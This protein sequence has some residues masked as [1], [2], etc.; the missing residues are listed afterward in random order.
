[1]IS[2]LNL[3]LV[4]VILSVINYSC[5][6]RAESNSYYML[7]LDIGEYNSNISEYISLDY[8]QTINDYDLEFEMDL[9]KS[10]FFTE[11]I[12]T[13]ETDWDYNNYLFNVIQGNNKLS[14]GMTSVPSFSKF[15]YGGDLLGAYLKKDNYQIWYGSSSNSQGFRV[16]SNQEMGMI[17]RNDGRK[18]GYL[19]DDESGD[20]NH[21]LSYADR[22]T[23]NNIDLYLESIVGQNSRDDLLGEAFS[24]SLDSYLSDI[25]YN[26]N[27]DYQSAD[28]EALKSRFDSGNGKYNISLEGYKSLGR[29]LLR[30]NLGYG[31]NN[32]SRR[33]SW[34]T[35]DFDWGFDI[36]YY[37]DING[38]YGLSGSYK[39]SN[40]YRTATMLNT[41]VEDKAELAFSYEGNQW[42]YNL[43]LSQ[44]KDSYL[45]SGFELID[46]EA[47]IS[48]NYDPD[49]N[50]WLTFD[51]NINEKSYSNLRRYYSLKL[52]YQRSFF[53]NLDYDSTLEL[54]DKYGLKL[55]LQQ[56][57]FYEFNESHSFEVGL[58][59]K[60]YLESSKYLYKSLI[61]KYKLSF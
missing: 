33:S 57:L 42:S 39:R 30:S 11:G 13:D 26:I 58:N 43:S 32:L 35:K 12:V 19:I 40:E 21:Y 37:G 44:N 45:A 38:V 60:Q 22:Y 36:D 48:I 1:M 16:D 53:N 7:K 51:Y 17:W 34:I 47:K 8:S 9:D 28:F 24:L 4:L 20:K 27:L 23:L 61:L 41:F 31:E 56:T 15:L 14:L 2:R 54:E 52:N 6:L 55:N 5:N 25:N 46:K 3:I 49:S 59:L 10:Y 50:Y 29:Y 18:V